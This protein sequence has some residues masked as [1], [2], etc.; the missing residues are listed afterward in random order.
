LAVSGGSADLEFEIPAG[1]FDPATNNC[2]FEIGIDV[3]NAVLES[4]EA[5]NN[6]AGVCGAQI[7]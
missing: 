3:G 7:F 2:N 4:N 6:A 5:N 1:C